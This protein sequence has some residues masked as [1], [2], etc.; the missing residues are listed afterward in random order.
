V[1]LA[2]PDVVVIADELIAMRRQKWPDEV[3]LLRRGCAVAAAGYAFARG[4]V[5][6]GLTEVEL[7]AGVQHAMTIAAGEPIGEVGNDF[8]SGAPGGP[9]RDRPMEAGELLP[10]DLGVPLRGY[11]ADLCR[12]IAVGGSPDAAQRDAHARVLEVLDAFERRARPG[13]S[14]REL[15]AWSRTQLH[16][17]GGAT[18]THHLGHGVGLSPHEA[19]RL[20]DHWDDVLRPGDVITAEPGLYSPGLR[21]GVRVEQMYLVTDT[22][23]D[24]LS[25]D[26]PT[27]LTA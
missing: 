17:F 16:G 27:G 24:R 19:P 12:T 7:F 1:P 23:L 26:I 13:T 18:F 10:L 11:V 14:C 6:P 20:N 3:E 4:A 9:P 22:G 21:A 2:G 8:Q 25:G 15:H 5:V